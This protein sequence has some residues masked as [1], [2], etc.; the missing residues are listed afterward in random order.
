MTTSFAAKPI[1]L[2]ALLIAA[3]ALLA[4]SVSADEVATDAEASEEQS[5]PQPLAAPQPGDD[6]IPT[7]P[8][9][10]GANVD[11]VPAVQ[12][13]SLEPGIELARSLLQDNFSYFLERE[14]L[15]FDTKLVD[16]LIDDFEFL[17]AQAGQVVTDPMLLIDPMVGLIV[18]T[19]FFVLFFLLERQA[20]NLAHRFQARAHLDVSAWL[21]SFTRTMILVT[22]RTL[23]MVV[24]VALSYFPIRATFGATGWTL[25]LTDTL[26]LLLVY[27]IIKSSLL[28]VLRLNPRDVETQRHFARLEHFAILVLRTT[29][30]FAIVL[31]AIDRFQYHEQMA[32]FVSFLFRLTLATLPI[33]LYVIRESVF[34][35]LPSR[36]SSRLYRS[37]RGALTRNYY[38]VLTVTI[39]L[40]LFNVA[41]YREAATFL[42]TRG[43][44]LIVIAVLWFVVLERL[45]SL[46][47]SRVEEAQQA[48][49]TPSPL[50]TALEHWLIAFGALVI[51]GITLR[52]LGLYD[53]I[54]ALAQ[55]PLL[56]VGQLQLSLYNLVNVILIIVGTVL[57]IRL[58]KAVLNAKLYPA[59][60]VDIGV[61]YATNTLIN[62]ALVVVAFILCLVALGVP[63][64]AVMVVMA[65]LG[66]GIGLGLQNIAENLLSGFILLFGRAVQKGDFITVNDLYGR[67][68]AVGARSVVVRTP[69]NF[70]MLIPSK[71]IVSGRIVNWTFHDSIVRI[72]IPVGVSYDSNATEVRQVLLDTADSH[73]DILDE[74]P[75][76][77]WIVEFGDS[78]IQFELLVHFDCRTTNEHTLKGKFNFLLWEAL[79]EADIKIPY[80]QRDLHLRTKGDIEQPGEAEADAPD[81]Q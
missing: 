41:G 53:P 25:L 46:V 17:R 45:H 16:L 73:P 14:P 58:F 69:D 28:T 26:L 20:T 18:V 36:S 40:L 76:D 11:D 31:A 62:Y 7:S 12:V 2:A 43:Y 9:N 33:F 47:E 38:T 42:L 39:I 59:F 34:S 24:L 15:G 77:V 6:L 37:L 66:V 74:P 30:G 5:Q 79:Q 63:L 21:T 32:A 13:G 56:S 49:G 71:E 75:P 55:V 35:L 61:A 27:R 57:S 54:I 52:L 10:G 81:E 64:S 70:S 44:A 51:A 22:G 29:I 19:L 80:P 65:S 4:P 23:A 78:S 3:A 48:D 72:H 60:N 68:E 50:L 1:V 8:L 67:V